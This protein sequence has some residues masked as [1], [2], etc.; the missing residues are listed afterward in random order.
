MEVINLKALLLKTAD[1]PFYQAERLE[2]AMLNLSTQLPKEKLTDIVPDTEKVEILLT[3]NGVEVK[4]SKLILDLYL[5]F[6]KQVQEAAFIL[7]KQQ[8]H[9]LDKI[10]EEIS[11][12][13]DKMAEIQK[14]LDLKILEK[15]SQALDLPIPSSDQITY[16]LERIEENY[17]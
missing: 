14:Y 10:K 9:P 16:I 3:I 15:I 8:E 1:L 6:R 11:K 17:E 7:Y 12:I 2:H 13:E 5:Q 4:F